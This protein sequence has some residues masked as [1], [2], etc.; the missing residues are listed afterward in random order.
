MGSAQR[1]DYSALGDSVN[2]VSRLEGQCKTYG[3]ETILGAS[4][5]S[6]VA[7]AGFATLELDLIRVKGKNEPERIYAL[8]DKPPPADE[9]ILARLTANHADL[10]AAYRDQRWDEALALV[11]V[12]RE[13]GG[14]FG[15]D[16]LYA[17]YEE[18]LRGDRQI[19]RLNSSHS[20]ATRMPS[21]V[22]KN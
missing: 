6:E 17:T 19:T 20:C 11:G 3:V 4:T 2:L 13:T 7:E 18:S 12:C 15:L 10:L 8:L 1:F 9:T 22:C 21:S 14:G 5:R 16:D